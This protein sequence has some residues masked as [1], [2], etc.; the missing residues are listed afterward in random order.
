MDS[1]IVDEM[2][3]ASE[4]GAVT[5]HL[6]MNHSQPFGLLTD[7]QLNRLVSSTAVTT[8]PTAT[9]ELDKELPNDL[10]YEKNVPS[11]AFT[12]ILSGKVTIF[13]GSENFRSD[14]SSWSV[15]GGKALED[16]QWAPDYS[17]FVSDGP[18]RFIQIHR[19]AF[20]E[21]ADASIFERRVSEGNVNAIRQA[22]SVASSQDINEDTRSM[23]S[24]MSGNV[25]NRRKD[26]LAKLFNNGTS[27]HCIYD[28]DDK[29][30]ID[31]KIEEAPP[32]GIAND[33][34]AA[35]DEVQTMQDE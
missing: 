6:K 3:S 2:L 28:E 17:A 18:C 15:L 31:K 14:I 9:Q 26:V 22:A 4:I 33:T 5:A 19:D 23:T 25:P 12:L 24:E 11:D 20:I 13:V 27:N 10:L 21:A 35:K 32:N 7:S 16:K 34:N 30:N 8:L 29:I 1:K